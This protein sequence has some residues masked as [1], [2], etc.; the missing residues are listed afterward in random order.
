M[1]PPWPRAPRRQRPARSGFRV[2]RF[3]RGDGSGFFARPLGLA[4]L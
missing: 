3:P 2:G 1:T 4:S